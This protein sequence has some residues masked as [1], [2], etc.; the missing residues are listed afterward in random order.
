MKPTVSW[1]SRY[2]IVIPRGENF[3][4]SIHHAGIIYEKP[5][6]YCTLTRHHDSKMTKTQAQCV[7]TTLSSWEERLQNKKSSEKKAFELNV[8]KL[9]GYLLFQ[10]KEPSGQKSKEHVVLRYEGDLGLEWACSTVGCLQ[11][12][13]LDVYS[14]GCAVL[15]AVV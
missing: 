8:R 9:V 11:M 12:Q 3:A 15:L 4:L 13:G 2:Q 7:G 10:E 14:E 5:A 6:S 1:E